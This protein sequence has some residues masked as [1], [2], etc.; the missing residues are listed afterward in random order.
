LRRT[1]APVALLAIDEGLNGLA[2]HALNDGASPIDAE[3]HV[4]LH[5]GEGVVAEGSRAVA[6]GA[7][8]AIALSTDELVGRFTDVTY[9]Y[10]FGPPGHDVTV[11]TLRDR[12]NGATLGRA[13][14]FP[15]S[16]HDV[17]A[18]DLGVEAHAERLGDDTWKLTVR[19]KKIAQAVAIDARGFVMDD[20]FFHVAPGDSGAHSTVLTGRGATLSGT[21]KALNAATP[22]KIT[23]AR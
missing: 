17:R 10:R 23:C 12:T 2:L 20:D 9:A 5:R 18:T 7:H 4:A 6:L 13:F 1:L 21:V 16:L 3:V 19:T 14:H 11:A 8:A 15:R 22:T